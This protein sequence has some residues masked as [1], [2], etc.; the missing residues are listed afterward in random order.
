MNNNSLGNFDNLA[1]KII[2]N[3]IGDLS[4]TIILP[5]NV[6][7]EEALKKY[8][9][10]CNIFSL[11]P[12]VA[13]KKETL[14][15]VRKMYVPVYNGD[16]VVTGNVTFEAMDTESKWHD[17]E[18]DYKKVKKYRVGYE[19]NMKFDKVLSL[20]SN[21]FSKGL[22]SLLEPF[23]FTNVSSTGPD[24][25]AEILESNLLRGDINKI[26]NESLIKK[27][28][29]EIKKLDNHK[30]AKVES[31]NLV[32]S[33]LTSSR[34]LIP[35]YVFCFKYKGKSYVVGINGQ[36]GELAGKLPWSIYKLLI[37]SLIVFI[38]MFSISCLVAY[39]V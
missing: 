6:S 20:E 1:D 38:L 23:D 35:V 31:N 29:R 13:V 7:K 39:F 9:G 5:F 16:Y 14:E 28:L 18:F 26:T 30:S 8:K 32:V 2:N 27:C 12:M 37:I 3:Y 10:K 19:C 4:D 25:D 22:L 36:S 17:K 34:A 11:I 15:T 33:Q 21:L 24:K